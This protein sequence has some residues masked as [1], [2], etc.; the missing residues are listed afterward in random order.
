MAG[1]CLR[2]E[3][4]GPGGSSGAEVWCVSEGGGGAAAV[5]LGTGRAAAAG[6][7]WCAQRQQGSSIK[8]FRQRVQG[9]GHSHDSHD[10]RCFNK[11]LAEAS[12]TKNMPTEEETKARTEA[13]TTLFG[14]IDALEKKDEALSVSPLNSQATS[15]TYRHLSLSAC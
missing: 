9:Q 6:Q 11:S 15:N 12:A 4:D 1:A 14:R 7:Q 2:L 10:S 13:L 8:W 5:W 3:I